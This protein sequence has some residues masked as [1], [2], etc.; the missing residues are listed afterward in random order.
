MRQRH[1]L[2]L[3]CGTASIGWAVTL[4]TEE[5][6]EDTETWLLT[7]V[8]IIDGGVRLFDEM[9]NSK[10]R[11]TL[12]ATRRAKRGARKIIARRRRRMVRLLSL[13]KKFGFIA[14]G[15][16]AEEIYGAFIEI[17]KQN[18][19]YQLRRKA[20]DE[21]ISEMELVKVLYH[22][23]RRRG[24]RSN[25]KDKKKPEELEKLRVK[26]QNETANMSDAKALESLMHNDGAAEV[27]TDKVYTAIAALEMAIA[28][29]GARTLGEY[30]ALKEDKNKD[31][32][33]DDRLRG[34]YLDRQMIED[35]LRQILEKQAQFYPVLL[36]DN[37]RGK[38]TSFWQDLRKINNHTDMI[39][40][41]IL[42]PRPLK[43][44]SNRIG[45]CPYFGPE[46]RIAVSSLLFQEFDIRSKINNMRYRCEGDKDWYDLTD[47]QKEKVFQL[48]WAKEKV[49]WDAIKKELD[50]DK[51]TTRFNF[52]SC[53]G[54]AESSQSKEFRGGR[55]NAIFSKIMGDL[56]A[57]LN[58]GAKEELVALYSL[59]EV[60]FN[61]ELKKWAQQYCPHMPEEI[62]SNLYDL[63]LPNSHDYASYSRSML[64]LVV[65]LVKEGLREQTQ[66]SGP[67]NEKIGYIDRLISEGK[68]QRKQADG[69]L[70]SQEEI[71]T[72][73]NPRIKKMLFEMRKLLLALERKYGET[74]RK[75]WRFVVEMAR[76]MRK[77]EDKKR[78][79]TKEQTERQEKREQARRQ[80]A[81]SATDELKYV[82]WLETGGCCAYCGKTMGIQELFSSA[83]EIE[84]IVPLSRL[85]N[86]SQANKTIA[87]AACN[88]KKSGHLPWE[89]W[90]GDAREWQQMRSRWEKW[91]KENRTFW[92]KMFRLAWDNEDVQKQAERFGARQLSETQYGSKEIRKM[93]ERWIGESSK[94]EKRIEGE[95]YCAKR[96]A[97]TKGGF[98]DR[99]RKAFGL[100]MS[101][102]YKDDGSIKD[103]YLLV[104]IEN[105]KDGKPFN[106]D[107][108]KKERLDH[109]HHFVDAA[110]MTLIG[111]GFE[112]RAS[113][114]ARA[115]ERIKDYFKKK[116]VL[117]DDFEQLLTEGMSFEGLVS[118]IEKNVKDENL[119]KEILIDLSNHRSILGKTIQIYENKFKRG[120]DRGLGSFI[121]TEWREDFLM[122]LNEKLGSMIVSQAITHKISGA[123]HEETC[124]GVLRAIPVSY[125]DAGRVNKLSNEK[126]LSQEVQQ[127]LALYVE[128]HKFIDDNPDAVRRTEAADEY[129]W[130][131]RR[132]KQ[133]PNASQLPPA[134]DM[135]EFWDE[136]IHGFFKKDYVPLRK[137]LYTKSTKEPGKS[138]KEI[139]DIRLRNIVLPA[140][141]KAEKLKEQYEA[142]RALPEYKNKKMDWTLENLNQIHTQELYQAV[143][144]YQHRHPS[145][146]VDY[147]L[148]IV[149]DQNQMLLESGQALKSVLLLDFAARKFTPDS[150]EDRHK[151]FDTGRNHHIA[152]FKREK[153]GEEPMSVA[154]LVTTVE[155]ARRGKAKESIVRRTLTQQDLEEWGTNK[156]AKTD[157][158]EWQFFCSLM[159]NDYVE[160]EDGNIYR[161]TTLDSSNK[162]AWFSTH[163]FAGDYGKYNAYDLKMNR[164]QNQRAIPAAIKVQFSGLTRIK[165]KVYVD[166]LGGLTTAHD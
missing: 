39:L 56:W 31:Q 2:G 89:V 64:E 164:R 57:Q 106:E 24:F 60:A 13:L 68:I 23:G 102:P 22:L 16:T 137:P 19:I 40:D 98:T 42:E 134:L 62:Y 115:E 107:K 47:E 79:D 133:K 45:E 25:R 118:Y 96:V 28:Q 78:K 55:T 7:D 160:L 108:N 166:V 82:L 149:T 152:V 109:R 61:K 95:E 143:S 20:L 15:M 46:K 94:H 52:E 156:A 147:I 112:Q 67:G 87:C 121:D 51:K 159:K 151:A 153:E 26:I 54:K 35:E 131:F 44:Q 99:I 114:M 34:I 135:R 58:L 122:E 139:A 21:K 36:Q 43:D 88:R 5:Y 73:N 162:N 120:K 50:L 65:P 154:V 113:H 59:G 110:A 124:Y 3:D 76:E 123:L 155:A 163:F 74:I 84:H 100:N 11:D 8:E 101:K 148:K 80:G 12:N 48:A 140:I 49:S 81:Q 86:D 69:E 142:L 136:T 138:V 130:A 128:E 141:E 126:Y 127:A 29:A 75:D 125:L 93:L 92:G 105:R 9:V 71:A 83:A 132:G 117:T 90:G 33:I 144:A 18:S 6:N 116:K 53:G 32:D 37:L 41:T 70:M 4:Q 66:V 72:I 146:S 30:F 157:A 63:D 165:Q 145:V 17:E 77:D 158:S 104:R 27:K 150:A 14:Q 1:V 85:V 38:Y 103:N 91:A 161:V 10:T 129:L 111:P 119:K 97:T